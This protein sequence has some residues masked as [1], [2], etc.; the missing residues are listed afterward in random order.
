[1]CSFRCECGHLGA[2]VARE[3]TRCGCGSACRRSGSVIMGSPARLDHA[4]DL[5]AEREE[6]QAN[7][8]ELELAVVARDR[9]RRP[10]SGCGGARGTS[11]LGSASRTDMHGPSFVFLLSGRSG[12]PE[13]HAEV[14]EERAPL[15]VGLRRRHEGDV[16]PLDDVDVV[17]VDLGEDDLLLEAERVVALAVEGLAATRRGSRGRAGA[18]AR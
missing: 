18:R 1:M 12:R 11:G 4:G 13:G 17:V 2:V 9:G 10:C 3:R 14:L 5:A 8:A 15:F 7:A 16:H 6:P